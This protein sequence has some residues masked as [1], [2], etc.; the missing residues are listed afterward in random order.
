MAEIRLSELKQVPIRESKFN[1][2]FIEI[3]I[4][5]LEPRNTDE[6]ESILCLTQEIKKI[7][8]FLGIK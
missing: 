5:A 2:D 6:L 8:D 7:K 1:L 4:S 3:K